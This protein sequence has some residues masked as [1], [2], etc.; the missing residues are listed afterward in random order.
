MIV[1][2]MDCKFE[3]PPNTRK[4]MKTEQPPDDFT[5]VWVSDN[6]STRRE[7][8]FIDGKSNGSV[9]VWTSDGQL[10]REGTSC[11]GLWHGPLTTRNAQGEI[12]DVSHFE[13]GTGIYRIFNTRGQLGWEINL[14][15]G[16]RHGLTQ[17]WIAGE[18]VS[19]E[20]YEH[21]QRAPTEP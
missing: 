20:R 7:I 1:C 17:R 21:G 16:K 5:G 8:E 11:D 18:L 15:A 3:T 14:R 2:A 10:L 12:L 19:V 6:G 13:H 4:R 9:R